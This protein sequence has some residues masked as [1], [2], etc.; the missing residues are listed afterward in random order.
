MCPEE[1][2]STAKDGPPSGKLPTL[3]PDGAHGGGPSGRTSV[4]AAPR[5]RR[6]QLQPNNLEGVPREVRGR[7]HKM[8]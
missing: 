1:T 3:W 7:L 6:Y 5:P 4:S 2:V 8:A